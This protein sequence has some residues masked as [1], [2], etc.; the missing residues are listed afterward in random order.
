MFN[1]EKNSPLTREI[2]Q[3]LADLGFTRELR[4]KLSSDQV[5]D[6]IQN[7][8]TYETFKA[9]PPEI[10]PD[11]KERYR[12]AYEQLEGTREALMLLYENFQDSSGIDRFKE[13]LRLAAN[14]TAQEIDIFLDE[15]SDVLQD[16]ETEFLN[17]A[18]EFILAKQHRA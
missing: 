18:K 11:L 12:I 8:I 9:K 2:E 15:Q 3:S 16:E 5:S 1:P 14:G 7:H 17:I 4:S 13:V 10:D 6:I